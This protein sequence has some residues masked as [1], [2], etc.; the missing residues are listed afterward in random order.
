MVGRLRTE[1]QGPKGERGIIVGFEAL[2]VL[3][4]VGLMNR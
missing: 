2:A 1:G 3:F 4:R